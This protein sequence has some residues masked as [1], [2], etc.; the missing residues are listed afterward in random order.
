[1]CYQQEE[2]EQVY[3]YN[4][5]SFKLETSLQVLQY[6]LPYSQLF[7]S[8]PS[9]Q[10]WQSNLKYLQHVRNLYFLMEI[11]LEWFKDIIFT[12]IYKRHTYCHCVYITLCV[13]LHG[14]ACMYSVN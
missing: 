3:G 11:L 8:S 13:C 14:H 7:F 9:L 1:M 10:K 2:N 5:A 6:H 12:F 4:I